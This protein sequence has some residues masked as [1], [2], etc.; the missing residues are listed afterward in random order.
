MQPL[1]DHGE[2]RV[3]RVLLADPVTVRLVDPL[4]NPGGVPTIERGEVVGH[5]QV[6]AVGEPEVPLAERQD[7]RTVGVIIRLEHRR[8]GDQHR[9]REGANEPDGHPGRQAGPST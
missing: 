4:R 8:T 2:E 3:A 7:R 5:R 1:K 6:L 9:Q